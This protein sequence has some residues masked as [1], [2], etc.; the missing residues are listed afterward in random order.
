MQL[1]RGLIQSCG[2]YRAEW[3]SRTHRTHGMY[4]TPEYNAWKAM[5]QRCYDPGWPA[6]A[7]YG[8]RCIT[9]C[10]RWRESF[11]AFFDDMGKRPSKLHTLDRINNDG[12][13]EPSN[14]RWATAKQQ[15]N[16]RRPRRH[17]SPRH[18]QALSAK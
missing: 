1:R 6:F 10:D 11:Q 15:A 3:N 16:N 13:Y 8:A 7:D 2:C 9:V 17:R 12:H 4:G 14:C 18:V 5:K